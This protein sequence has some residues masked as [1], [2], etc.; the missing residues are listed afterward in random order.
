MAGHWMPLVVG[1]G[2]TARE[3]SGTERVL[4]AAL[5]AAERRGARTELLAAPD[6]DLPMYVPGAAG[7]GE[8]A[9]ALVAALGRADGV[10]VAS[11]AYH[12]TVSGL[13]KNALDHVEDLREARRPYLDGRAVG[14][15]AAAGG[16]QAAGT[17]LVGL[18][19]VVHAL[20]GWPTPL[21]VAVNT[22]EA[23][24]GRDGALA[25]PS[26]LAAIDVMAAQVVDFAMAH[27]GAAAASRHTA[28]RHRSS[29]PTPKEIA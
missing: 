21:G 22:S 26:A 4:R 28:R 13:V 17:T 23:V 14:C 18:R 8:R 29:T 12:G 24:F 5:A 9:R 16:W 15:V 1:L 20:R 10:I 3:G 11:P 19:S 6:L 2:G 7:R 25:D 27:H